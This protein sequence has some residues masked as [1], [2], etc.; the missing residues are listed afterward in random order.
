MAH[1]PIAQIV[2]VNYSISAWLLIAIN[3]KPYL[4]N[5]AVRGVALLQPPESPS[6]TRNALDEPT[7]QGYLV[8]LTAALKQTIS[9]PVILTGGIK[10]A[11]IADQ[12]LKDGKA[13][14]IGVGRAVMSDSLW[15][16]RAVESLRD[17]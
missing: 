1:R 7:P 10:N 16:K 12:L 17:S 9:I 3:L 5:V 14:L 13:D 15:A 8:P 2:L 4:L 6:E 11:D